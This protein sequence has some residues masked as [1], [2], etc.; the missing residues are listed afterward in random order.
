MATISCF[1]TAF[2]LVKNGYPFVESILSILPICDEFLVLEAYSDDNTYDI[3]RKIEGKCKKFKVYR[4]EK[5]S[6]EADKVLRTLANSIRRRCSKEYILFV[7]ANEVFH[8]STARYI[9]KLPDIYP[10]AALFPFSYLHLLGDVKFREEWRIMFAKNVKYVEAIDDAWTLGLSKNFII[11][12]AL[13]A[14]IMPRT[15]IS[16]L[17]WGIN[18]KFGLNPAINGNS[19]AVHLPHPVFRYYSVYPSD[20]FNKIE[21]HI[22]LGLL[23]KDFQNFI[24]ENQKENSY[25]KIFDNYIRLFK[26]KFG[27]P[28]SDYGEEFKYVKEENHPQLMKFFIDDLNKNPHDKYRIRENLYDLIPCD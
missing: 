6:G 4:E 22:R 18:Y 23:G 13:M 9:R 5:L 12:K 2:N 1:T 14:P 16:Y 26:N 15:F 25:H 17:Y 3:L 10:N 8:D 20:L 7:Q 21:S 28:L 11:R 27:L 24:F 19:V